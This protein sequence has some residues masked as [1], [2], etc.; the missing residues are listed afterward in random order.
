MN[1]CCRLCQ[2]LYNASPP[3]SDLLLLSE[4]TGSQI[5]KC[6]NCNTYMH[7]VLDVWEVFM[8]SSPRYRQPPLAARIKPSSAATCPA[9]RLTG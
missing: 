7:F 8:A 5:F 3:H 2:Q 4:V 1:Q 9:Q 6:Q